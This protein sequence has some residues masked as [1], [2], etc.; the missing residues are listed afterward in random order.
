MMHS[1]GIIELGGM[2]VK[3]KGSA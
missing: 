3:N 1:I 2:G